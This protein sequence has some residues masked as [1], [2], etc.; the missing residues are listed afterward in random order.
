MLLDSKFQIIEKKYTV[1]VSVEIRAKNN[2]QNYPIMM[3]FWKK[4][5]EIM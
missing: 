5:G 3:I 2:I 4:Y 1:Y